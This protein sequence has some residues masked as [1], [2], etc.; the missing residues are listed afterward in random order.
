MKQQIELKLGRQGNP[1]RKS[2][3]AKTQ[4]GPQKRRE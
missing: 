2:R 3:V 1:M 4:Y